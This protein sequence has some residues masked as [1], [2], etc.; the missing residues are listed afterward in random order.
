MNNKIG[1]NLLIINAETMLENYDDGRSKSFFCRATALLDVTN[2]E[3]A[4]DKAAQRI[5]TADTKTRAKTVKKIIS[6]IAAKE[7]VELVKPR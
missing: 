3:N 1:R 7:G 4:L 6:E 2:L 5:K